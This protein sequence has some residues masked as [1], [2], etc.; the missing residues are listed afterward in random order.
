MSPIQP[1]LEQ[2]SYWNEVGGPRWAA[3]QQDLDVELAPFGAAVQRALSLPAGAR[4]LDIGCGAGATSLL[5]AAQV[6]PG[7]VVGVDISAPLLARAR[8]RAQG[9]PGL[10]F[11]LADA[12]TFPFQPESF[13]AVFSR[14]GVMFF[15]DPVAAFVNLSAA[16]RYEGKLGFVC[17]RA[18]AENPSFTLPFQAALPFLSELPSQ[19][20]PGEPGPFAFAERE[21]VASILQRAGFRDIVVEP[22]DT[23]MV[24]AGRRDLEGAVAQAF[25][26][27][28][29]GRLRTPLEPAVRAR[30]WDAVRAAFEP[31]YGP[32]GVVLPAATWL[33]TARKA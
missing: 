20:K 13:D 26:L 23:D 25:E 1:N 5:L 28:P 7:E 19:P 29:L 31:H 16:L 27:G 17:W 9:T 8:E 2:S 11:E 21:H 32:S 18:L 30:V 15:A 24:F 12:Q 14:F 33:V 22:Y 3:M 10:R 6:Q 4:V